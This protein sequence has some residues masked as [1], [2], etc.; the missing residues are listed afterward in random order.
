MSIASFR[1][2]HENERISVHTA[3]HVGY[4][5]YNALCLNIKLFA[6]YNNI[7]FMK[8][9]KTENWFKTGFQQPKTGFPKNPVLT[10]LLSWQLVQW[11]SGPK[12]E[13][14]LQYD[15]NLFSSILLIIYISN[16]YWQKMSTFYSVQRRN[17]GIKTSTSLHEMKTGWRQWALIFCVVIHMELTPP[18]TPKPDLSPFVWTS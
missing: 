2:N 17:S 1:L 12:D 8:V 11:L 18:H 13:I 4:V 10:S 3:L 5:H 6:L 7:Y 9:T 14:W 16:F 15:C